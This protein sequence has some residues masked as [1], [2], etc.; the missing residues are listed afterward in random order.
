MSLRKLTNPLI[1]YLLQK[2]ISIVT[3]NL[4]FLGERIMIEN[5]API[6]SSFVEYKNHTV[7]AALQDYA[8]VATGQY[9]RGVI[10]ARYCRLFQ[11][12]GCGLRGGVGSLCQGI[13]SSPS[14]QCIRCSVLGEQSAPWAELCGNPGCQHV[15]NS[16]CS[17]WCEELVLLPTTCSVAGGIWRACHLCC[18]DLE[19]CLHIF[20]CCA[21]TVQV[22]ERVHSRLGI[23]CPQP[24]PHLPSWWLAVRKMINKQERRTFDAGVILVTWL[25]WKEHNARVFEGKDTMVF[26]LCAV[27]TDEWRMWKVAG[28]F[29]PPDTGA[30]QGIEGSD[31]RIFGIVVVAVLRSVMWRAH[32]GA[33]PCCQLLYA[34]CPVNSVFSHS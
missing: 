20:H 27:I 6:L 9:Q 32:S 21:C 7:A 11:D 2:L 34:V 16:S 25:I 5:Q 31:V 4:E 18:C 1:S 17:S 30:Y 22:W 15:V 12:L 13:L 3:T 10:L 14:N 29:T 33:L 23:I 26:A 19:T 24:T 8:W 28:L